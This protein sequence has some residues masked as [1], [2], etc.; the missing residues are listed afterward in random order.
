M[1]S[2]RLRPDR[3]VR[4]DR[5]ITVL[6]SLTAF[7]KSAYAVNAAYRAFRDDCRYRVIVR[8]HPGLSLRR[9]RRLLEVDPA[10]LPGN[11]E[12][13]TRPRLEDDILQSDYF[14]Y[15]QSS[16]CLN[17]LLA[18]VPVI[19]VDS[20]DPAFSMD[21]IFNCMHLKRKAKDAAAVLDA[22]RYFSGMTDEKFKREQSLG[23][24]YAESYLDRLSEEKMAVFL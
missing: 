12:I 7:Y 10:A 14:L 11:F 5:K 16:T 4:P 17:A 8:P 20:A 13:S 2:P 21:P 22:I 3:A 19:C 18:G 15:D 1:D 23:R 9:M 24:E 6:V